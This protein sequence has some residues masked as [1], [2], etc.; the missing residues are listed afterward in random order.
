[1]KFNRGFSKSLTKVFQEHQFTG[2]PSKKPIAVWRLWLPLLIQTGLILSVPAQS[3]HTQLTGKTVVLQTLPVD[4]YDPFRGYSM[5]L[6]YDI[7][8]PET[9]QKLPGWAELVQHSGIR[10]NDVA[11][12][13]KLYVILQQQASTSN[14]PEAWKPVKVS[15]DRPTSIAA[16]QVALKGSYSYGTI[17]YGLE[18]YYIPEAQHQQINKDLAQAQQTSLGQQRQKQPIVVEVKVDAQGNA[19]PISFWVREHN[20]RF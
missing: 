1:M 4:P 3:I 8:S 15:S 10:S 12:G 14:L 19:V 18:T 16:N 13:T 5:T 20:Y 17:T 11:A 9:L 7:S 2:E 6:N